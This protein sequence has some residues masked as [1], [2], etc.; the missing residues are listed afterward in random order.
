VSTKLDPDPWLKP[1]KHVVV[2]LASCLLCSDRTSL[3]AVSS[4]LP[5]FPAMGRRPVTADELWLEP[6]PTGT[7]EGSIERKTRLRNR[8]DYGDKI[9]KD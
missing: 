3:P 5:A 8:D 4:P 1:K 2:V 9:K 7:R 6:K